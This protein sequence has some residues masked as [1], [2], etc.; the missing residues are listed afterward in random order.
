VATELCT[1]TLEDY[2]IGNKYQGPRFPNEKEML[3]QLTQGLDHLHKLKIVH[4]DIKP[5]N[6]LIF[7]NNLQPQIKLA[8]FD[9]AKMIK[10]D[11]PNMNNMVLEF[12]NTNLTNPNGLRG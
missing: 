2:I 9:I 12:T 1:A 4:R 6:I 5:T 10:T 3:H 8:D 7:I 11:R